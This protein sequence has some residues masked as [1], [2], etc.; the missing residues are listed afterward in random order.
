MSNK[1]KKESNIYTKINKINIEKKESFHTID[2]PSRT[3]FHLIG[4]SNISN[5]QSTKSVH[6]SS[7]YLN[8]LE[9]SMLEL[10]SFIEI[11][12]PSNSQTIKTVAN[13]LSFRPKNL[14]KKSKEE[15][16]YDRKLVEE[17]R[18]LYLE[19]LHKKHLKEMEYKKRLEKKLIK[20]QEL[21]KIWINDLIPNWI[22]KKKDKKIKDY[23]YMGLPPTVRGRIWI[24]C[25]GN[26]FSITKEYYQIQVNNSK[27]II[28]KYQR[29][30]IKGN[31]KIEKIDLNK[32][33]N[34][35]KI[36]D[37]D[38]ENETDDEK[39]EKKRSSSKDKEKSINIIDLDIEI[40]FPYLGLFKGN[41]PMAEDLREILRVFVISRPDIGYIQGLSFIAG[42]LLLNMDKY[43][44]FITLMNL[45]LNP[46]MLPFYKMDNESIQQRLK[47]FKQV[48]YFNLPE[49]CEHFDELGLL[50]ENYF[51]SWNMTLFTRD[52]NLELAYRIW[53]VF[54]I[55]GVKAIYSAA[56]VF[57][58][59]FEEKLMNMDFVEIMTCIGSIKNINFDEDMVIE[60]MKKIKI[61]DWVQ[62]EI[63]KLNDA[64][65]PL[66]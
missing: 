64:N 55:E 18:K 34:I 19:S 16:E 46:I 27:E 10:K 30:Q 37:N 36:D 5:D 65:I 31:N 49:L 32:D 7:S 3:N 63:D 54:M 12:A 62:F 47:L 13:Q 29:K 4:R 20:Q 11:V 43:K 23:F 26:K 22:E 61:P 17:N 40:T 9:Q 53:D 59:H 39:D 52:V 45:I 50:P 2:N 44:A 8:D 24:L 15:E 33:N 42:L 57:L 51:L 1:Q 38:I 14:P 56:V 35:E 66:Y 6:Y 41:T 28:K 25:L 48:F 21:S 60:A 58:S